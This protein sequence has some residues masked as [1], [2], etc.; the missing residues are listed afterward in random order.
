[1]LLRLQSPLHAVAHSPQSPEDE[2]KD[3]NH[4]NPEERD[5]AIPA[6]CFSQVAESRWRH[7]HHF[8]ATAPEKHSGDKHR[9]ARDSKRP[10]GSPLRIRKEPWTKNRGDEGTSVDG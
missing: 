8:V 3:V 7:V 4:C 6:E 9:Y 5:E 1:H 2:D 10:T